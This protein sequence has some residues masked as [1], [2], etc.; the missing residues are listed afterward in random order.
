MG[1]SY[2]DEV[3]SGVGTSG[4]GVVGVISLCGVLISPDVM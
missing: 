3:N 2:E 1:I 4:R